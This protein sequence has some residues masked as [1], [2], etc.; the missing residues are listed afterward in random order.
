MKRNLKINLK[1][2]MNF[3]DI[4]GNIW[5]IICVLV[6]EKESFLLRSKM[7]SEITVIVIRYC[8]ALCAKRRYW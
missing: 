8:V 5:T 1:L 4:S 6:K 3:V 2:L 7:C